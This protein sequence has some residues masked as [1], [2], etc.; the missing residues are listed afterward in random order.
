MP[1]TS[2]T[3]EATAVTTRHAWRR[4]ARR[5]VIR[6]TVAAGI[7]GLSRRRRRVRGLDRAPSQ[8]RPGPSLNLQ[9]TSPQGTVDESRHPWGEAGPEGLIRSF[10][11]LTSSMRP[12]AFTVTAAATMLSLAWFAFAVA[13][14]SGGLGDTWRHWWAALPAVAL[15]LSVTAMV[16]TGRRRR[17]SP[18]TR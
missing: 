16:V 6:C 10:R 3:F 12:T 14:L 11:R 2:G 18:P 17:P 9:R 13:D 1:R 8:T 15:A 4:R 7:K 5:A